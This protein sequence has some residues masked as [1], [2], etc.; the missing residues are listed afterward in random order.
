MVGKLVLPLLGATPQVWTCTVLFFQAALL[1]GYAYGHLTTR[2]SPRR[3][4]MLQVAL[5][6][7]AAVALPIGIGAARP[8]HGSNPTPWLLG[9]LV[10]TAGA[11]FVVLAANAPLLQR[12]LSRVSHP[13]ARDPYFLFAA[14]NGGSLLGLLAYPFVIEPLLTLHSQERLWS[15]GY[16]A[17]G[18][19]ALASAALLWLRPAAPAAVD[20]V[21]AADGAAPSARRRLRWIALALVPSSL[22]L[23]TT[24]YLTRDLAPIPL[25]WVVPLAI[26]LMTFV[27][28]F[29]PGVRPERIARA[30]RWLLP[31]VA[32]GVVY[33]LAIGSQRP[34]WLLL[35]IHLAGLAT[36]GL[37]CHSLLAVD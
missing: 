32:V 31:G 6:A 9:L 3:Q 26:Y 17:V 11:P 37:M 13:A 36:A 21:A 25:L 4:A 28:A 22:M 1:A 20:S 34:L 33:T 29:A 16:G 24:T 2:L 8:P 35:A 30:A 14:S 23:G 27:A 12:W 19:L 7:A 10:T 18:A 15:V 5:I